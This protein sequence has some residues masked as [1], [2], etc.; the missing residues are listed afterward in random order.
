M[1][2][3]T[4]SSFPQQ[5]EYLEL[6]LTGL[7]HDGR[8]VAR[9]EGEP[10]VFVRGGLPG[11][12][13]L[14][15]LGPRRAESGKRMLEAELVRV[16]APVPDGM[17][18]ERPAPCLHAEDCG[19]CPWQALPYAVQLAWKERL[20]AD[21]LT[22]IGR[23]RLPQ[24]VFRPII[25][26]S[27]E[28][29][30]RN[31]MEFAFAPGANGLPR[32]GLRRRSSREVVEISACLLASPRM[33][34][35]FAALREAVLRSG[36]TAWDGRNGLLRHAV[37]REAGGALLVELI[38]APAPDSDAA[39]LR[40]MGEELVASGVADGFA[41]SER[42]AK[43][44][45]AYGERTRFHTGQA[46]LTET[47]E[48]PRT[49]GGHDAPLRL[50]LGHAS[51][52]QI[53]P[54]TA[55]KLYGEALL[56]ALEALAGTEARASGGVWKAG[57]GRLPSCWD[58]YCGVGG[59]ALTMAPYFERV[60]GLESVAPAVTLA[61]KNAKRF[62]QARFECADA[63]RLGE[64][65]RRFGAP[66]LLVCDPPRAGM[67]DQ[68]TRAILRARPGHLVLISCNPATLARDLAR[69]AGGDAAAYEI[70]AVRPVDMFPQTPHVE[71]V[72]S[73]RAKAG[74][75]LS[76]P[77]CERAAPGGRPFPA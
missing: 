8:C 51:F 33:M 61:R 75:L 15:R 59:L 57:E 69:L 13:V 28:W 2:D 20:L 64:S 73:L 40:C 12:R 16:L 3:M 65:F 41:H 7:S 27:S 14:A 19:G 24:A 37:L 39:R 1:R 38:A 22:R 74:T 11:Q 18:G 23:L 70:L 34:R 55:S 58:L 63:A 32:L 76:A 29:G 42:R 53:N 44:D 66:D 25:P 60:L 31:K 10:V 35:A 4:A 68:V 46:E 21:A 77:S 48:L 49:P 5:D 71:S 43:T 26:S 56:M 50:Q 54:A 30:F 6:H 9:R 47:L 17:G 72:V 52:F 45:V 36:L 62:P 67:N